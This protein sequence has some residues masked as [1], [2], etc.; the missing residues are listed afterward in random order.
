[1]SSRC[2]CASFL[3]P[4]VSEGCLAGPETLVLPDS[5]VAE[6]ERGRR[7]RRGA[8]LARECPHDAEVGN[9]TS[10]ELRLSTK[11]IPKT[12]VLFV[13]DGSSQWTGKQEP[14]RGGLNSL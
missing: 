2:Y 5:V 11:S 3:R 12:G 6:I 13:G 4:V 14:E 8:A 9:A 1:V 7:G 10:R